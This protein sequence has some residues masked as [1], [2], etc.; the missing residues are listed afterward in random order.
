MNTRQ[1]LED[2]VDFLRRQ[3]KKAR[4]TTDPADYIRGLEAG[5]AGAYE[6]CAE[7]IEEIL[8]KA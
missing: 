8:D 6:C 5:Y 7:W 3:V 2:L 1:E 4:S